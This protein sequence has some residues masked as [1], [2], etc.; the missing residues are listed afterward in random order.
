M[1]RLGVCLL[2]L[3]LVL[4]GCLEPAPPTHTLREKQRLWQVRQKTN[5]SV[6]RRSGLYVL[7]E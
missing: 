1:I 4:G 5:D 2:V 3:V 7:I 6:L